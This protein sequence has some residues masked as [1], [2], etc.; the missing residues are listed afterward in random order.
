LTGKDVGWTTEA[1]VQLFP[2]AN[3]EA[4]GVR[5]SA[6]LLRAA[7]EK[8]DQ[9]LARY[10]DEKDDGYTAGLARAIPHL[11]SKLHGKVRE[12]L[13]E[14]L[15]RLAVDE[16]RAAMQDD[17]HEMS[18]AAAL[19]CGRKADRELTPELIGLLIHSDQAV[20]EGAHKALLQLTGEDFGPNVNASEGERVAAASRWQEWWHDQEHNP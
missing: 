10:R 6:A 13:A 20:A 1:W 7:P 5:L 18:H 3:A 15:A 14:R 19:A 16:L 4:E 12:T 8:R 2:H 17:D 9:L 11:P